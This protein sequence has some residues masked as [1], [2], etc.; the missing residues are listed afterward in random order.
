M[1][2]IHLRRAMRQYEARTGQRM[3]YA[4]LAQHTGISEATLQAIGSRDG[5]NTRLSTIDRLCEVLDCPLEDLLEYKK[6]M[7][8]GEEHENLEG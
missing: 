4:I 2:L 5:Y 1:I 3:T 7:L 8:S 6:D